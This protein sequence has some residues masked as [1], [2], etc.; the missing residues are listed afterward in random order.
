MIS[1]YKI[2]EN[3]DIKKE[4]FGASDI[5]KAVVVLY[6]VPQHN[7]LPQFEIELSYGQF[8]HGNLSLEEIFQRGTMQ[9]G[10]LKFPSASISKLLWEVVHNE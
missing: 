4:V 8:N 2:L 9:T 10:G 3:Y 6:F 1:Q 7:Y 5:D